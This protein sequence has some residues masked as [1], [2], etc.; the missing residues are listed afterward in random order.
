MSLAHFTITISFVDRIVYPHL[1]GRNR[2]RMRLI[3]T[4]GLAA[5]VVGVHFL[6]P[7]PAGAFNWPFRPNDAPE[8]GADAIGG[9]IAIVAGG[10]A[11]L[12]DRIRRG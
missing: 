11:M 7:A 12:R 10:L 3:C 9:A 6:D 8:I 1:I 2:M 4:L 5:A